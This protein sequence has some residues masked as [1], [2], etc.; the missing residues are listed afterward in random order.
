VS[1]AFP[2]FPEFFFS[3]LLL[4][5]LPTYHMMD[6]KLGFAKLDFQRNSSSPSAAFCSSQITPQFWIVSISFPLPSAAPADRRSF[7]GAQPGVLFVVCSVKATIPV[8]R[9][10]WGKV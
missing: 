4:L 7:R 5:R 2:K 8:N 10:P 1:S 3:H 6:R 9:I